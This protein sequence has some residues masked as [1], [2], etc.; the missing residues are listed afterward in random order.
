MIDHSND[1][2]FTA[3]FTITFHK[4][5]VRSL[6]SRVA[7]ISIGVYP[8]ELS[9]LALRSEI[10]RKRRCLYICIIY[11]SASE[12]NQ[13]ESTDMQADSTIVMIVVL[14][15]SAMPFGLNSIDSESRVSVTASV[16]PLAS[17]GT[18]QGWYAWPNGAFGWGWK[19]PIV[20]DVRPRLTRI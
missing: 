17:W 8:K 16:D 12:Q 20:I 1:L 19:V 11:V 4:S 7:V 10:L 6:R 9:P 15:C 5:L 3:R 18:A 2:I 13:W 14:L